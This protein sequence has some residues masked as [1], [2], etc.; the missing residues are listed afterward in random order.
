MPVLGWRRGDDRYYKAVKKS[1]GSHAHPSHPRW[2]IVTVDGMRVGTA[3]NSFYA[4]KIARL[5]NE[6]AEKFGLNQDEEGA[7]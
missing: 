7:A 2:N 5:L 4:E 6:D 1:M 3:H